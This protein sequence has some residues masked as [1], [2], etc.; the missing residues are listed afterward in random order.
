L[1]VACIQYR[2]FSLSKSFNNE[3][4]AD[5]YIHKINERENLPIKNKFVVFGGRAEVKLAG[6][7][8]FICNVKDLDIVESH[9]C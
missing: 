9:T 2:D 7:L 5:N 8:T 6:G 3:A 4:D 1:Y